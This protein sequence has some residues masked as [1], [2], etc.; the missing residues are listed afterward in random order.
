[1]LLILN[2]VWIPSLNHSCHWS[3]FTISADRSLSLCLYSSHLL[4]TPS[5]L[6]QNKQQ[7]LVMNSHLILTNFYV[8]GKESLAILKGSLNYM[9]QLIAFTNP[10]SSFLILWCFAVLLAFQRKHEPR[11]F[12]FNKFMF[13]IISWHNNCEILL[14]EW[15][16][17]PPSRLSGWET[18]ENAVIFK[19]IEWQKVNCQMIILNYFYVWRFGCSEQSIKPN[20]RMDAVMLEEHCHILLT[21]AS[22]L[23]QWLTKLNI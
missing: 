10:F 4:H 3:L 19:L 11:I 20:F 13:V 9:V 21:S 1:M 18:Y 12:G 22:C 16:N 14:P 5:I 17:I 23:P 7:E 2:F 15:Q 6:S 8:M